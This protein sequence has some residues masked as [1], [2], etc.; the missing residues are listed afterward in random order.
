MSCPAPFRTCALLSVILVAAAC[1]TST[2]PAKPGPPA[3]M[4]V[5]AGDSQS[6][7]A[8]AAL[9]QAIAVTVRDAKGVLVPNVSVSFAAA[10]GSG[11]LAPSYVVT[12]GKGVA[13]GAVWTLGTRGGEQRATATID[14]VVRNITAATR[15][16]FV[17]T[18]RFFGPTMSFEAQSAF[19]NA[20]NRI[21]AAIVGQIIPVEIGGADLSRCGVAGLSGTLNETSQGVIIYASVGPIDGVSKIL[22]QAGPCYVRDPS[23]H[24]AVGV[25]LFDEAD[26]PNY[27]ASGRFESVVLHEMNHVVGFGTIWEDKALLSAPAWIYPNPV[28]YPDSVEFTGSLNPRFT[29]AAGLAQ[30]VAAGGS[31]NHCIAGTGVAVEQCGT[32]GTADGHW[33]E[34]FTTT[35]GGS[36]RSPTGGTVA[37]DSELMTGYVEGNTNMPWSAMSIASFQDLGYTVNLLAADSYSVPNLMTMARLRAAREEEAGDRPVERLL[38]PRFTIGGGRIQAIKRRNR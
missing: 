13:T 3:R 29:G 23:V 27:I 32:A 22:A 15:S 34:M 9:S 11:S 7:F 4:E 35:C 16:S 5:T 18:L 25:M 8:G 37:F 24:P 14:T 26:V 21:R 1:D 31:A 33:R 6:A 17:V 28:T 36:N 10:A 38:R 20:V 2:A 12:D 19:T 30:C